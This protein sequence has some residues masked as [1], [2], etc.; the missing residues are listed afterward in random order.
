MF[1]GALDQTVNCNKCW[2]FELSWDPTRESFRKAKHGEVLSRFVSND[3]DEKRFTVFLSFFLSASL[4][5]IKKKLHKTISMLYCCHFPHE[6]KYI[7]KRKGIKKRTSRFQNI[8]QITI[9]LNVSEP[10]RH[11][12]ETQTEK[13]GDEI[14]FFLVLRFLETVSQIST[15]M[16]RLC[17]IWIF[18]FYFFFA[19]LPRALTSSPISYAASQEIMPCLIHFSYVRCEIIL[20]AFFVSIFPNRFRY[21]EQNLISTYAMG[22]FILTVE[23]SVSK[24]C[25]NFENWNLKRWVFL[26]I[27]CEVSNH[28]NY[29]RN[30]SEFTKS[31]T[32]RKHLLQIFSVLITKELGNSFKF[33]SISHRDLSL[34][35]N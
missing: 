2:H 17:L 1:Y 9:R 3:L 30:S 5:T 23:R 24:A 15:A 4:I 34:N 8:R 16:P 25:N 21:R 13:Q 10:A 33:R 26:F 14:L 31:T 6:C 22:R 20:H 11:S 19:T 27:F 7:Q 28:F 35:F 32:R 29:R 18:N 12:N